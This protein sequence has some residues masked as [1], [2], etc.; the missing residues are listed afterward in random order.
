M[1]KKINLL[2][3]VELQCSQIT[4]WSTKMCILFKHKKL[5]TNKLRFSAVG[6]RLLCIVM[7][8]V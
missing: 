1:K 4:C 2:V 8:N 3:I 7:Y 6:Q 5:Y